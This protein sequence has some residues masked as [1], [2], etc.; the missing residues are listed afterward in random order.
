M[1]PR[2]QAEQLSTDDVVALIE[3]NAQQDERIADL[4]AK[5]N[6]LAGAIAR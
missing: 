6:A 1:S 5:V 2:E 3:R 4:E